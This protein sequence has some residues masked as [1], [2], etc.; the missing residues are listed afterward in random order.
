MGVQQPIVCCATPTWVVINP[1]APGSI[2]IHL[3][4][5]FKLIIVTDVS[6]N[7]WVIVIIKQKVIIWSMSPYGDNE[8]HI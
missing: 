7:Y 8:Y 1:L 2:W 5:Y 3:G 4:K 6:D